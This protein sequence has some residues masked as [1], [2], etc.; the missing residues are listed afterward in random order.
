MKRTSYILIILLGVILVGSF[1]MPAVIYKKIE[2]SLQTL[3][4]DGDT[5]RVTTGFFITFDIT[6]NMWLMAQSANPEKEE[7]DQLL[8]VTVRQNPRLSEAVLVMDRAWQQNMTITNDSTTLKVELDMHSFKK[9]NNIRPNIEIAP[10][11]AYVLT[12]EVPAGWVDT[13]KAKSN[14]ALTVEDFTDSDM[15]VSTSASPSFEAV[16]CTFRQLTLLN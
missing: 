5:V 15:V 9:E 7:S 10:D 8:K 11:A 2:F 16:N 3:R 4:A 1:L 6:N 12:L 14:L 13:I